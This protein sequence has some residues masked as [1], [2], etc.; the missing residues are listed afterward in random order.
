VNSRYQSAR[1]HS[2]N[3]RRKVRPRYAA[4]AS[5]RLSASCPR[6]VQSVVFQRLTSFS[7][8]FRCPNP[9][10]HSP[11]LTYLLSFDILANS[12]ASTESSTRLFS[13]NSKL[14]CKNTRGWGILHPFSLPSRT[15]FRGNHDLKRL[16]GMQNGGKEPVSSG[17]PAAPTLPL[18]H[19]VGY[20]LKLPRP[21]AGAII[22]NSQWPL[23]FAQRKRATSNAAGLDLARM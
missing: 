10:A 8:M 4:P 15:G 17:K 13:C 23:G 20:R 2:W 5:E 11:F 3:T 22:H 19:P 21:L 7:S 18:L 1:R 6:S 16:D 14:F 9:R 12:F